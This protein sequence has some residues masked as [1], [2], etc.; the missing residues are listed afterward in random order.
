MGQKLV[1]QF[2]FFYVG[3]DLV[4]AEFRVTSETLCNYGTVCNGLQDLKRLFSVSS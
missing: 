2:K 1:P 3:D 4:Q